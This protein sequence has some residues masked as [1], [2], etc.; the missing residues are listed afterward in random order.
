LADFHQVN[1][2]GTNNVIR[3]C[4]ELAISRLVFTSS[5][6][7]VF[8]GSDVEGWDESAPYARSF[9]S[10]Y[11]RTKATAEEMVLSSNTASLATVALRPHLVWGPGRDKL[12]TRLVEKA[13]TGELC[14]I[15]SLNKKVDTTYLDDAAQAHRLALERLKPGSPV[16]GKAYFISAGEPR[17]V[18]DIINAL[19]NTAGLPPVVKTVRPL[20]ARLAAWGYETWYSATRRS[21]EPRLTRFLLQQLTTAHWFDISAARRDLGYAPQV[22]F[23]AGLE[24]LRAWFGAQGAEQSEV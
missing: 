9:D 5:P 1:V 4:Q 21:G 17:P 11:S 22:P 8:D 12:I 13:R 2:T 15:G 14:R 10:H 19:L 18:W 7:V 20:S 6:S 24:R 16:A 23:A 3:A